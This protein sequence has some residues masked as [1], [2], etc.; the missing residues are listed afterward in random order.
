MSAARHRARD[1]HRQRAGAIVLGIN[2][3]G[4][5]RHRYRRNGEVGAGGPFVAGINTDTTCPGNGP[6]RGHRQRAG[7]IVA[8]INAVGGA[9]HR[10][11]GDGEV[12][13]GARVAGKNAIRS[14]PGNGP[15]RGHRQRAGAEVAGK[16]ALSSARDSSSRRDGEVGAGGR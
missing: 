15:G 9:R 13:A 1:R 2:A 3:V 8:G 6:G 4:G 5:A 10:C 11:C 7:A 12:G 14:G 16:N